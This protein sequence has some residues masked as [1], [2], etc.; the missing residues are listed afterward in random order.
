MSRTEKKKAKYTK[1]DSSGFEDADV[2][3]QASRGG[4][5]RGRGGRGRGGRGG[6]TGGARDG[7]TTGRGRGASMTAEALKKVH[8]REAK[9][10]E[11]GMAAIEATNAAMNAE[12][13][14][15]IE[16][17]NLYD[18]HTNSVG[19]CK[20]NVRGVRR[21]GTSCDFAYYGSPPVPCTSRVLN[22]PL[23]SS[24]AC[25]RRLVHFC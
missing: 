9:A 11:A 6:T 13:N 16:A 21:C 4:G 2:A 1:R 7:S 22:F 25:W 24:L 15:G 23:M 12:V 8:I 20:V 10:R 17:R 5:R 14:E 19:C 3:I 18:S